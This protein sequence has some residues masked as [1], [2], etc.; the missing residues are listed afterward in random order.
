VDVRI[1]G[2]SINFDDVPSIQFLNS[3]RNQ[4][5]VFSIRMLRIASSLPVMSPEYSHSR[6]SLALAEHVRLPEKRKDELV[7]LIH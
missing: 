6:M 5:P 2:Q 4:P 7:D 3:F 1:P